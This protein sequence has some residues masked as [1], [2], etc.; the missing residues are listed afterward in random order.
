M[1]KIK[2]IVDRE[3][4]SSSSIAER[5][6]FKQVLSEYRKSG[7]PRFQSKWVLG[8]V[9]GTAVITGVIV[10][11]SFD[12]DSGTSDQKST[13]RDLLSEVSRPSN[14]IE[15]LPSQQFETKPAIANSM[16]E[17][18]SS[19]QQKPKKQEVEQVVGPKPANHDEKQIQV[20]PVAQKIVGQSEE[21]PEPKKSTPMPHIGKYYTGEVPISILC[22]NEQIESGSSLAV[23]AYQI[24]FFDGN[25]E[26]SQTVKGAVIPTQVCDKLGRYNL[27]ENVRITSIIGEDRSTGQQ[28]Q[29]P[30][31]NITPIDSSH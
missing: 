3:P 30:S 24:T 22:D 16:D 10:S 14:L 12:W 26:V 7:T 31:M 20:S 25:K 13:K 28:F 21:N 4:I 15:G 8:S 6:D 27:G 9:I 1:S 5:Q 18:Q 17:K 2:T 29:L 23:V 11:A 19:S